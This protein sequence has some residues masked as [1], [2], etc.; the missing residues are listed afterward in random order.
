MVPTTHLI[1]LEKCRS[2]KK[3]NYGGVLVIALRP[4]ETRSVS[5]KG[6]FKAEETMHG[7]KEE[8]S[9]PPTEL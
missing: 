2:Q 6:I 7:E 1:F 8:V 3:I 9:F 4:K 5:W